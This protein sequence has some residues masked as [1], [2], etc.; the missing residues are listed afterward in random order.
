MGAPK[1][2]APLLLAPEGW[3]DA[4][5]AHAFQGK[6]NGQESFRGLR[7]GRLPQSHQLTGN[8][9]RPAGTAPVTAHQ[10]DTGRIHARPQGT[11]EPVAFPG[12]SVSLPT[13]SILQAS[14]PTASAVRVTFKDEEKCEPE[15]LQGDIPG[16][17]CL[18]TGGIINTF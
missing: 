1:G 18:R 8:I 10:A 15:N 7:R 17:C 4:L 9:H 2:C 13:A 12:S 5:R 6:S 11:W 3:T 14:P 16:R